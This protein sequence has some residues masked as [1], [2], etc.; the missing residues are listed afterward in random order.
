M[1][2]TKNA[3]GIVTDEQLAEGLLPKYV[4][5]R[6]RGRVTK[7]WVRH[8]DTIPTQLARDLITMSYLRWAEEKGYNYGWCRAKKTFSVWHDFSTD[9]FE[10]PDP[11]TA[12]Y[13]AWKMEKER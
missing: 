1:T 5:F 11:L 4:E 8:G 2:D 9:R 6:G 3:Q 7:Y 12:L 13:A 10:H